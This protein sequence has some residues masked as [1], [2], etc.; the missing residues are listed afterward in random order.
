MILF[1]LEDNGSPLS[2]LVFN[3]GS[4]LLKSFLC[5]MHENDLTLPEQSNICFHHYGCLKKE[6]ATYCSIWGCC[7]LRHNCPGS[8]YEA[9]NTWNPGGNLSFLNSQFTF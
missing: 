3:N 1:I 6:E 8:N 2:F 9:C 4:Q 5:L 7:K